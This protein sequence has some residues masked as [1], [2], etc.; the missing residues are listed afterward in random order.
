MADSSVYSFTVYSALQ[1]SQDIWLA[2]WPVN[3]C[4]SYTATACRFFEM[5]AHLDT[6]TTALNSC[7]WMHKLK[8]SI[9]KEQHATFTND[10]CA[11]LTNLALTTCSCLLTLPPYIVSGKAAMSP[12]AYTSGLLVCNCEFTCKQSSSA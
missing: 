2:S 5:E 11:D 12:T 10:Q 6:E 8:P 4:T 1:S 7:L 9:C 3:V